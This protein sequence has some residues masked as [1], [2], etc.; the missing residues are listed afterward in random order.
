MNCLANLRLWILLFKFSTKELFS[1]RIKWWS[2]FLQVCCFFTYLFIFYLFIYFLLL[3]MNSMQTCKIFCHV[4][5][6][7]KTHFLILAG[8]VFCQKKWLGRLTEKRCQT[9]LWHHNARVNSHQRWKQTRFRV[10]FH[11]GC[12]L[13]DTLSAIS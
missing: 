6:H 4:L 10:C 13:T 9:I 5:F 12:E 11:L 1:F 7:E 8:S 2:W 3:H